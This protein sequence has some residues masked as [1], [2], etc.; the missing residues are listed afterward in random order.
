MK[1]VLI[2]A[3][4]FPPCNL[5][6]GHRTRLLVRHL[7]EFQYRPIVMTSRQDLYE[8][9]CDY[10]LLKMVSP[11][12]EIIKVGGIPIKPFRL[13]GDIGARTFFTMLLASSKIIKEKKIDLVHI[14]IPPNY[15]A[16]LGPVL[17]CFYGIPFVI[18]YIDPW[19]YP[20]PVQDRHS[21]KA[22]VSHG[23]NRIL[24]PLVAPSMD[25]VVGVAES[26]LEGVFQRH[27]QLRD[28]PRAGVPYGSE[29]LDHKIALGAR[30]D[31]EILMDYRLTDCTCLVYAGAFLPRS[32]VV[33][34]ALFKAINLCRKLIPSNFRIVF[35]GTGLVPYTKYGPITPL[36]YDCG[37]SD[38]VIE[39]PQRQ[40]FGAILRLLHHASGIL[41]LGSTEKHYTA[42]KTFQALESKASI[43]ALLHH[44]SH[45][46][47]LLQT[48]S[49]VSLETFNDEF[50]NEKSTPNFEKAFRY[51]LTLCNQK[52]D[53]PLDLMPEFS[54][55]AMA[56]KMARL[57]DKVLGFQI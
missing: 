33:A 5:T 20:I 26:Y 8:E 31:S 52:Y 56:Q 27:N 22:M 41:V 9:S 46:A 45:A 2:I 28:I 39:I 10:E 43:L 16:L 1:N 47:L 44:E 40:S 35:V 42:S 14:P 24:E 54:A 19:V 36:A 49:G 30:L 21:F 15:S 17:K 13:L 34:K 12:L 50:H 48:M 7:S 23:I 38:L 4:Q 32:V 57:Y 51:W 3:P 25:G 55:K 11:E 37:V 6:A 53:R 29:C 18:D